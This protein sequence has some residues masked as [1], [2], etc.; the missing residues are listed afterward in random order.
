MRFAAKRGALGTVLLLLGPLAASSL[1]T[2]AAARPVP[3]IRHRASTVQLVSEPS[4]DDAVGIN[5][6][7]KVDTTDLVGVVVPT[8]T[9]AIT[10]TISDAEYK[11]GLATV[12]FITLLFAS[13]SPAL[14]FAF[15]SAEHVPPVLLVS[16]VASCTA[17]SSLLVGG[18]LLSSLPTPS[19][20]DANASTTIDPTSIRAGLELGLWKS[21]GTA[22]N[23]YGLS[24]TSA[25]HG[26]FLIQMTTFIVPVVQGIQ[27][28]P[29][30]KRIWGAVAIALTGLFLFT[31]DP[32]AADPSSS[33]LVSDASLTGDLACVTAACFYALYDLRLFVW[34][35]KVT[36][37]RLIQNKVGAQ[38]FIAVATL[39]AFGYSDASSFFNSVTQD[40]LLSIGPL[41]L[42]SGIV[43][44]GIA[45]FLQVGGQQAIGP[46]RAQVIY[47]S[48]PL[49]AALIS[50]VALGETVGV[51]GA[52]G[53]AAFLAATLL[54]ATAPAPD[55]NCE[56][57]QCEA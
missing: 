22:A 29:I 16:A 56:E 19:T 23:L 52:V 14:R 20:L 47:A 35:K 5:D 51:Q 11:R 7:F 13:N 10:P 37:L 41:I 12:A 3:I 33:S 9:P 34:G 42:W 46:S 31:S 36:P 21:L 30:P 48:G 25:S 39:F 17:L 32:A 28:V 15:T 27:G 43:V 8:S 55:P 50:L 2:L 49:W 57:E 54:A 4:T 53:G 38:A 26:A 44:N 18:P 24:L 6:A 1:H 40:E 45:P